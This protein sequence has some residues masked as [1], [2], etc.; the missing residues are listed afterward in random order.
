MFS[1]SLLSVI[2]TIKNT[3]LPNM[4]LSESIQAYWLTTVLQWS[5][6]ITFYLP[7]VVLNKTDHISLFVK[8]MLFGGVVGG[9]GC[10][11]TARVAWP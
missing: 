1:E 5:I 8:D 6:H 11:P 9:T 3:F 4:S 2:E 10:T 7:C